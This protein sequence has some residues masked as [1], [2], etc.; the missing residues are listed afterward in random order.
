MRFLM[1]IILL[2]V[3]FM[4]TNTKGYED[5]EFQSTSFPTEGGFD[6]QSIMNYKSSI[7]KKIHDLVVWVNWLINNTN[8]TTITTEEILPTL[9]K[10]G[11]RDEDFE[12]VRN[13]RNLLDENERDIVQ[14]NGRYPLF[15]N[16][17]SLNEFEEE[18]KREAQ[19]HR[20]QLRAL[21]SIYSRIES[22]RS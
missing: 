16:G 4:A 6:L 20:Q 13:R 8:E 21:N 9:L 15:A 3:L 17:I 2:I 18:I 10:I 7:F 1:S 19:E 11:F 14:E 12:Y 5:Q 22:I